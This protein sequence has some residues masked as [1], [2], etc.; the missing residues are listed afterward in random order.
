[1]S[2]G[3]GTNEVELVESLRQHI[4]SGATKMLA[5]MR[6]LGTADKP[7]QLPHIAEQSTDALSKVERVLSREGIE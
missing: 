7:P 6:V 1:M 3:G 5:D 2:F 4:H